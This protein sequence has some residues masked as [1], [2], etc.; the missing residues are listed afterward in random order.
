M[1]RYEMNLNQTRLERVIYGV[2]D[3]LGDCGGFFEAIQWIGLA[4]LLFTQFQPLN[5]F[6]IKKLYEYQPLAENEEHDSHSEDSNDDSDNP[7]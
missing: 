4:I 5:M 7:F 3:W 1:L 6:L 2:L